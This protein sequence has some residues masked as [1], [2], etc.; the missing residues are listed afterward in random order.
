[1][2][3]RISRNNLELRISII[4]FMDIH[5]SIMD[6]LKYADLRISIIR[7]KDGRHFWLG[8]SHCVLYYFLILGYPKMNNGYP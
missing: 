7:F 2:Y 1:M 8:R 3:L 6:I 4:R 5:N